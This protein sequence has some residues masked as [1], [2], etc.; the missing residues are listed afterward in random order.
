M[1]KEKFA[2][3]VLR[4][5]EGQYVEPFSEIERNALELARRNNLDYVQMSQVLEEVKRKLIEKSA[6][7]QPF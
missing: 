4:Y 5:S 2:D 7:Q 6:T 1:E 3:L